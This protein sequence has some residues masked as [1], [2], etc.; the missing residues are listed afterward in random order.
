MAAELRERMTDSA[1]GLGRQAQDVC[2]DVADRVAR[3]AHE[4]ER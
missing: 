2:D 1:K 4:V 3:G